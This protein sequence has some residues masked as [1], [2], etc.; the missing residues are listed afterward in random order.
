MVKKATIGHFDGEYKTFAFNDGDAIQSLLT[1]ANLTLASG[2]GVDDDNGAH[3]EVGACVVDGE[4]YHI[5]GNYKQ[6]CDEREEVKTFNKEVLAES[7]KDVDKERDEIKLEK[8]RTFLREI[9]SRKDVA[10]YNLEKANQEVKAIEKELS[11][12]KVK[13]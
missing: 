3:V 12:F 2:Q 1:K 10:D 11:I 7:I 8:A 6:G 4:T 13:K 9:L 5:V